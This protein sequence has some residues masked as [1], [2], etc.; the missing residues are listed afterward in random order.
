MLGIA[1]GIAENKSDS[2]RLRPLTDFSRNSCKTQ[3][4]KRS[5]IS[6]QKAQAN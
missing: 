4:T 2:T 5:C 3:Q 6:T 1:K